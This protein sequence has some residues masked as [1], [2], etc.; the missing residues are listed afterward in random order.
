[1][2]VFITAND[3]SRL[4]APLVRE[5][6][7]DKFLWEPSRDEAAQ[8]LTQLFRGDKSTAVCGGETA[9]YREGGGGSGGG[10]YL[11]VFCMFAAT[12]AAV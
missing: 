9:L 6:R 10:C 7:M 5:G 2:P 8:L 12:H 3:L 4:Y 1:M 11:C